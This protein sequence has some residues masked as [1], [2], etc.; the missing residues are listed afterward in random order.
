MSARIASL[1]PRIAAVDPDVVAKLD[2]KIAAAR[3][4]APPLPRVARRDLG[5]TGYR[6][7]PEH[8]AVQMATFDRMRET[9]RASR[10]S[11]EVSHE[12]T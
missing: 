2:A 9:E 3:A 1:S 10:E 5:D 4:V 11:K 7:D 12:R 8:F 6:A